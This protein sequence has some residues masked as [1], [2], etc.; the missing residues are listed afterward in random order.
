MKSGGIRL[1]GGREEGG[2]GGTKIGATLKQTVLTHFD[3]SPDR[4]YS[5]SIKLE[6]KNKPERKKKK[7]KKKKEKKRRSLRIGHKQRDGTRVVVNEDKGAIT[8]VLHSPS[9]FCTVPAYGFPPI[10]TVFSPS[11][12]PSIP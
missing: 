6:K 11:P 4:A 10:R 8:R 9:T 7:E 1:G 12:S 5:H 2:E 3:S